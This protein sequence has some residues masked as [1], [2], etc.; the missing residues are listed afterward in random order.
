MMPAW[1]TMDDPPEEGQVCLVAA[2]ANCAVQYLALVWRE[3]EFE[4]AFEMKTCPNC[5]AKYRG[6]RCP[7]CGAC[8]ND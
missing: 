7:V 2:G 5:G 1:K 4:W 8:S 6:K 3:G